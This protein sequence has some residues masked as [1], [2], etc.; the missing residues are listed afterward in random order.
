MQALIEG[1]ARF[2][3]ELTAAGKMVA[4][5]RLRP[6]TE[7]TRVRMKAGHRQVT[8]GPFAETKEAIGGFYLIESD[9]RDEALEWARKIPLRDGAY[10]EVRPIWPM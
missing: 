5:Q 9:S 3:E 6:E 8:D 10:V 1:H 2:S 4:S 7:A